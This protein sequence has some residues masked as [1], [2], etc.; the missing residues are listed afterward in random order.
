MD[1]VYN[2]CFRFKK[3]LCLFTYELTYFYGYYAL[4]EKNIC[5]LFIGYFF[6]ILKNIFQTILDVFKLF[7]TLD[8]C[9]LNAEIRRMCGKAFTAS[10]CKHRAGYLG[11]WRITFSISINILR[12]N[13]LRYLGKRVYFGCCNWSP[14]LFAT[15]KHLFA[16][17]NSF[18]NTKNISV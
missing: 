18:I 9:S 5:S 15:F 12:W 1:C 11:G 8:T 17:T 14:L 10:F 7:T 13:F 4:R 2:Q 3:L 16:F 6:I